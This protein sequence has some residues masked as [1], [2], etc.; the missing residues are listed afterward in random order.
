MIIRAMLPLMARVPSAGPVTP[1]SDSEMLMPD[2]RA[3][4]TAV[5]TSAMASVSGPFSTA[6][7]ESSAAGHATVPWARA[8]SSRR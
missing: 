5:P 4:P 3:A 1:A 7:V 6:R 8:T 2:R